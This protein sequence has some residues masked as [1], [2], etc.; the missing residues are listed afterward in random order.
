MQTV[1]KRLST[2]RIRQL[3]WVP[4]VELEDGIKEVFEWVKRFDVD[5]VEHP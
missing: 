1:V 3:G 4:S 5:S 2:E